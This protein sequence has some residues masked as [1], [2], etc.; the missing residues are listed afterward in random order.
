MKRLS[1]LLAICATAA[2]PAFLLAEPSRAATKSTLDSE[3]R[4]P[5]RAVAEPAARLNQDQLE[6]EQRSVRPGILLA[7]G[8]GGGG[9]GG[10]GGGGGGG[11]FGGLFGGDEG[12]GGRGNDD[13]YD[14]Q[15]QN[16]PVQQYTPPPAPAPAAPPPPPKYKPQSSASMG[17]RKLQANKL[18]PAPVTP[19]KSSRNALMKE[20]DAVMVS[21]IDTIAEVLKAAGIS[22]ISARTLISDARKSTGAGA[23]T[24]LLRDLQRAFADRDATSVDDLGQTMGL[25]DDQLEATVLATY[26]GQL[27]KRLEDAEDPTD[28]R[29]TQDV[30]KC[31]KKFE[32]KLRSSSRLD[33]A[34]RDGVKS[35]LE[36]ILA[37][38]DARD[39]LKNAA[40]A[41][42]EK[43]TTTVEKLEWP[44]GEVW[45]MAAPSLKPGSVFYIT[46]DMI[47]AGTAVPGPVTITR[48]TV[49]SAF[50]CLAFEAA[51]PGMTELAGLGKPN[52]VTFINPASSG[53]NF[54]FQLNGYAYAVAPGTMV[55]FTN[56]SDR[57]I[58][59]FRY[60]LYDGQ[61][62]SMG[63]NLVEP[64]GGLLSQ[65]YF[66]T[67][68]NGS[69]W[70][71]N[72]YAT[73]PY[74]R[75]SLR[76]VVAAM[77][78]TVYLLNDTHETVSYQIGKRPYTLPAGYAQYFTNEPS[79]AI[80]FGTGANAHRFTL[81]PNQAFKFFEDKNGSPNLGAAAP[82]K[83][84]IDNTESRALFTYTLGTETFSVDPMK[85]RQ[86]SYT[87]PPREL[88]IAFD[89]GT[90]RIVSMPVKAGRSYA[91]GVWGALRFGLFADKE[92]ARPLLDKE[93]TLALHR[94]E[95]LVAL[96]ERL[97]EEGRKQRKNAAVMADAPSPDQ[98]RVASR[99][100]TPDEDSD[101][102]VTKRG[103]GG[104]AQKLRLP[105]SH[106][107]AIGVSKYHNS[108]F[109]LKYADRD[110]TDFAKAFAKSTEGI[111]RNG[112]S[113]V[114]VND[115]ATK[116]KVE[117]ALDE[118]GRSANKGDLVV[119]FISAHG[120]SD[121][122]R[123]YLGTHDVDPQSLISTAVKYTDIVDVVRTL[124]NKD[125]KILVLADTCNSGA[126][127]AELGKKGI[128]DRTLF[129]AH[130]DFDSAG[131]GCVLLAS[132]ADGQASLE[133]DEWQHGAFTKALLD[134]LASA[135]ADSDGDGLLYVNEIVS[136]ARRR[137]IALTGKKQ[138]LPVDWPS[139]VQ[140]F[141]LFKATEATEKAAE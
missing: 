125:C 137:L 66:I 39:E 98:P 24:E 45:V 4:V 129:E 71:V 37:T 53:K 8:G 57:K 35:K 11:G 100:V 119:M 15:Q 12:G 30:Q 122:K 116:G 85:S 97:V 95:E 101:E 19:P 126:L 48:S 132:S 112:M 115:Q 104:A 32:K 135:D 140:D 67:S 92:S 109:N 86:H 60:A 64:N 65:G 16:Y 22:D 36:G 103:K 110:A 82:T 9:R 62:L 130:K 29:A 91:V 94:D 77:P 47:A 121:D 99:P 25:P 27:R 93:R 58:E 63:F 124:R 34:I 38:L 49:A 118:L 73:V 96:A 111:F 42:K 28:R 89:D 81:A 138:R 117:K 84:T 88:N 56:A 17:I 131:A 102:P 80:E 141:P 20:L 69:T 18:L 31:V 3:N 40:D 128:S 79:W 33:R 68:W 107:L 106:I 23:D 123:F 52:A 105:E 2:A 59:T 43:E 87:I 120:L 44:T 13:G 72:R 5:P 136:A 127:G 76:P 113:E 78:G 10:G 21:Q 134:T 90:G 6:L 50:G 1:T 14:D 74:I 54:N 61:S 75:D 26:I 41:A 55:D 83:L 139:E 114:L 70:S 108:N 51:E 46:S 7:R 133:R